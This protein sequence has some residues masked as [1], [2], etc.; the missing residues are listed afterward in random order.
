M[1]S[2]LNQ[3]SLIHVLDKTDGIKYKIGEV[4][5]VSQPKFNPQ[6]NPNQSN[7][8]FVDIK[9]KLDGNVVEFNSIPSN[10]SIITY[11]NGKLVLSETK[12]GLQT[13]VENT[14]QNSRQ[15]V[16]NLDKYKTTI[17]ECESILKGLN[18]Q[19]AKDKERDERID[20]LNSKVDNMESKLD[21]LINL[22]SNNQNI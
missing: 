6:F 22:M 15:I 14:L 20:S 11:D 16:D 1:F 13:E 10:F 17:V 8:T 9:I 5:G 19:F 18:P 12:Q 3:G 4:V 21:K 2:A 7:Q